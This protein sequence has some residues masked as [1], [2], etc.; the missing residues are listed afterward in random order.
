MTIFINKSSPPGVCG[1]CSFIR[2][3]D[4]SYIVFSIEDVA[5]VIMWWSSRRHLINS[6]ISPPINPYIVIQRWRKPWDVQYIVTVWLDLFAINWSLPPKRNPTTLWYEIN[7]N[8]ELPLKD[9]PIQKTPFNDFVSACVK[10]VSSLTRAIPI[11]FRP[12]RLRKHVKKKTSPPRPIKSN[13]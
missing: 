6:L 11:S 4:N 1:L 5:V 3:D 10:I 9:K 13:S 7:K 12:P 2:S 8:L